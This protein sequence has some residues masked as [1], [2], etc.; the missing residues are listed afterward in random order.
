M[1][2]Y[3]NLA[4]VYDKFMEHA[5]YHK[6]VAF[7]EEIVDSYDVQG[8]RLLDLGCGTGEITLR[9]SDS[10]FD[11]T[12]VDISETMLAEAS[13]KAIHQKKSISWIQQDIRALQ[14]FKD[15][16]V[17]V[18]YCDVLNYVTEKDDIE[19]VCQNVFHSLKEK[20]LFIFDIHHLP[21]VTEHLADNQFSDVMDELAYIWECEAGETEGEM[22][23]F[24]TFFVREEN[25]LFFRYDEYH[26]QQ[27]YD[28][29]FYTA[30]LKK[31]GFTKIQFYADFCFEKQNI[32]QDNQ[33]IFVL[34][35]K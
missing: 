8:K 22:H 11:V 20:G 26:H 32:N 24:I 13:Q 31:A 27:T 3:Q 5:P 14:G 21:Y 15:I 19:A 6:W 33:R 30:A 4:S 7:T 1:E 25:G 16:D 23:H 28:F 34:A 18:S 12:G 10:G 35:E 29:E 2:A 17:C 9:L